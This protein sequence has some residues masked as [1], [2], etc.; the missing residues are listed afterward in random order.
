[1]NVCLRTNFNKA[2]LQVQLQACVP[3][4]PIQGLPVI[5]Q[6]VKVCFSNR[7]F[8]LEPCVNECQKI[9]NK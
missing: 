6:K 2:I 4:A 9:E 5:I 1:M 3:L 7:L 8:S